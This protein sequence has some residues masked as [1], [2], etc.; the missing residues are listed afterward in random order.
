MIPQLFFLSQGQF[1]YR[2]PVFV[3][4]KVKR[5]N[6]LAFICFEQSTYEFYDAKRNGLAIC[7]P[8]FYVSPCL[9]SFF[10]LF[11]GVDGMLFFRLCVAVCSVLCMLL[12]AVPCGAADERCLS[13]VTDDHPWA[14]TFFSGAYTDRTVGVAL[15]NF[16]GA[17]E[18]NYMHG[19]VLSRHIA[20]FWNDWF[21]LEGEGMV[22]HHHGKH[23]EARQ[24]YQEYVAAMLLRYDHFP[25]NHHLHTSV[26]LGEGL[27]LASKTPQREV[28]IRGHSRR[29]LNYLAFELALT[30]PRHPRYSLVYRLHH[31]SGVFGLF[32]NVRG[33]SD[34]YLLGLR[35][36][37]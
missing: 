15:S 24:S 23:K 33:A 29:L 37:F 27:S 4:M 31:R 36:R 3:L 19:I 14:V 16:P 21:S 26:A 10:Q 18:K 25:W 2:L 20:R 28:Q 22:A 35:Y 6:L 17:L 32:D 1:L 11:E 7:P 30:L 34:Y 8:V 12:A 5:R 13:K 9:N